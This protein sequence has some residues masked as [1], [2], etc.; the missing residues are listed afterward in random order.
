MWVSRDHFSSEIE[1]II[2][3]NVRPEWRAKHNIPDDATVVFVAPGNEPDEAA[4]S[5]VNVQRGIKEFMLKYS[6]P[7]SLSP[8]APPASKFYTV[9]ST[10]KGT[11]GEEWVQDYLAEHEWHGHIIFVTEEE[12]EHIS[13]MAGSDFGL[14]YDGQMVSTAAACHLPTMILI[15]M[16]M[17]HQFYHDLYNRW[18]NEMVIIANKNIYPELIGGEAW[19]GKISDTLGEWY[20]KPDTRYNMIRAWENFVKDSMSYKNVDREEVKSR[21]IFL[22]DGKAYDEFKDPWKQVAGHLWR[23]IQ[24]YELKTEPCTDF[25][26]LR[27]AVPNLH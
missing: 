10:H 20:I 1:K 9:I 17:Y 4:F 7:T 25:Q 16:R 13:A 2:E 12:N 26:A 14:I 6:S 27:V 18:A 5:M 11:K 21:D 24:E 23:D 22:E 15:K 8:S 3:K 19:W